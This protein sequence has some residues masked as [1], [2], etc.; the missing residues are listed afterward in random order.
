MTMPL[1]PSRRTILQGMTLTMFASGA[2]I[3]SNALARQAPSS[4]IRR[5]YEGDYRIVQTNLREIDALKDPRDIARAVSDFGANVIVS[6][7]GGIIAF[8]PTDLEYHYRNPYLRGDFAGEMIEAAHS[9]GMAYLGRFDLAKGM[10]PAF[11]AHPEWFSLKRDGTPREYNGTYQACPNGGWAQDYSIQILTEALTRYKPDGVFFNGIYFPKG[12]WYNGVD[13]GNCVC[14]NCRRAFRAMYKRDLPKV[15]DASDPAWADYQGFQRR[16][17]ADLQK[18]IDAATSPLLQGAPIMGR[19]VV[20]RGELQRN[21]HRDPPEWPYQG[22]EQSRQYMS[23]NPGRPWSPTSASFIDFPWRQV[24]ESAAHHELRFAQ[25]MGTGGHLDLYLMGTPADQSHPN[26]LPPISRLFKW[27]AANSAAY[28]GMTPNARVGLYFSIATK[29]FAGN[30]ETAGSAQTPFR[31]YQTGVD[32]GAYMMLVDSRIPFQFVSDARVADGTVKLSDNFDVLFLPNTLV[33]SSAEAKAIDAF[34]EA[35]GLLIASG[36]PGGYDSSGARAASTP[37]ACLPTASFGEF[38]PARGWS[39]D[40][41]KG[42]L[43]VGGRVPIDG[44]YYGGTLHRDVTDLLPFAPDQRYGPPEFSYAVP[45]EKPR[46][47]PGMPTRRFGQ[48][49]AVHVP[50]HIDWMYYRDGL[51]VHQEIVA[52]LIQQYAARPRFKLNGRGA[53]ELMQLGNRDGRSLVHLINYAGQRNGRYDVPPLLGGLRLGV[54]GPAA[55]IRALVSGLRLSARVEDGYSWYDLP[56]LGA[57]E[58]LLI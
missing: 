34:V 19:S 42:V 32:R 6:N 22:G 23:V 8:Y 12:N 39:L 10:P 30:S 37:L 17:L 7:I 49:R 21:I 35:G 20:G 47:I 3:A 45:G 55:P 48:G 57:F 58:A 52:A 9:A 5:W 53:V 11:A 25:V 4:G 18:K 50:W 24:T 15:D 28:S 56:P 29:L 13:E 16:V 40:P 36:M 41:T 1:A 31:T 38:Q 33:L 2:S 27:R 51:P 43:N 46:T 54:R 44:N 14:D 26:W